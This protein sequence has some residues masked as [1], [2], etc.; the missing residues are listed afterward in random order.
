MGFR[1]IFDLASLDFP[2]PTLSVVSTR[3]YIE[4]NPD[5]ITNV[6]RA[7]SEAI[8]L[9]RTRPEVALPVIAK[10]M[11]VPKDDP[12]L[13]QAQE[14][15]AK[16]LNLTLDAIPRRHQVHP[17]FSRRATPRAQ[18]KKSRGFC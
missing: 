14:T 1:E 12:A 5:V 17:G 7:T 9:Y 13:L 3:K 16:H 8:H 10:Y 2:F 6:L 4:A 11:R 18:G 15:F